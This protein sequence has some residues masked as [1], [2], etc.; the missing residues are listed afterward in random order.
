MHKKVIISLLVGGLMSAAMLY[1]AFRNVQFADLWSYMGTIDYRW[2]FPTVLL[3]VLAFVLRVYRWRLILKEEISL[4]FWQAFH[5][6]MIG[7]MMNC[8]L[9]A[10]A[11]ELA[12]PAILTK[13]YTVPLGTGLATVA[14]ERLFD[15]IM[16]IS[17]L[18]FTLLTVSIQPDL[19]VSIYGY[20]LTTQSFQSAIIKIVGAGVVLSIGLTALAFS[21]TR[22]WII[23]LINLTATFIG[24]M[25]P[26]NS[27]LVIKL[28]SMLTAFIEGFASG[29]SL[30]GKPKRA[31]ACVILSIL[32]WLISA[33]SYWVFSFGC[34]G[35][36]LTFAEMTAVMVVVCF[37]IALPGVPGFWG[38]WEAGGVF[39]L[40]LFDVTG[41]QAVGFTLVNHAVNVFPVII[42]GFI[43]ALMTSVNFWQLTFNKNEAES[44]TFLEQRSAVREPS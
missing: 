41:K 15:T 9:P 34:P 2:I 35:V 29:L 38:L 31:L 16:M 1:L 10:R 42:I 24:K 33:L 5:P 36:E 20:E 8:V 43:S 12:R 4:S 22:R 19:R 17:L 21:V 40:I 26:K 18:V 44:K 3:I 27:K 23:Q 39:A 13:E 11:G 7:F 32:V 30:I 14:A 25:T 37:F 28:S 6:L